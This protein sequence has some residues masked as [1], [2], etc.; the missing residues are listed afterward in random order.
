[1]R[2]ALLAN[3]QRL[4]N[5]LIITGQ[6]QGSS[7]ALG[8]TRISPTYAADLKLVATIGTGVASS[9]PAGPYQQ[10]DW[11]FTAQ[12]PARFTMLRL[13]G[14]SIPAGGPVAEDLVS[15]KGRVAL[16]KAR[17]GCVDEMRAPEQQQGVNL[18]N[19]FTKSPTE[20]DAELTTA[21]DMTPVR[22]PVPMFLGTGL[23]DRTMPPQRQYATAAALCSTGSKVVWRAYPGISHNGIVNAAFDD[24]L[25]FV[26]Q[27]L[28][29]KPIAS[30]PRRAHPKKQQ[31]D[32]S[33]TTESRVVPSLD[34]GS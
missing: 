31:L 9:F 26:Q 22:M 17:E 16:E 33:S 15:A 11:K 29:A 25:T 6:S 2:A 12:A 8:A 18:D 27:V 30:L 5:T 14:G 10:P 21:T 13:V 34:V 1:M 3:P 24:E 19:A 28:G 7:S 20:L 32:C 23:A 4:A